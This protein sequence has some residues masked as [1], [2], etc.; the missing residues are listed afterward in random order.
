MLFLGN[1]LK[2]QCSLPG[3]NWRPSDYETDAL[4]TEPK[5]HVIRSHV[6]TI[7]N[8]LSFILQVI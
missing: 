2:M 6:I 5:E 3:S 4:P 8:L 7:L 1:A